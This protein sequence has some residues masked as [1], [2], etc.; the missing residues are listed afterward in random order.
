[1]VSVTVVVPTLNEAKSIPEVLRRVA[2]QKE[3]NEIIVVDGHSVDGTLEIARQTVPT[4]KI[5]IQ[6]GKGKGNALREGFE[7]ASGE[8][9]IAIDADGSMDPGQI[10]QFI[11]PLLDGYDFAKGSRFLPG[12]GTEDMTLLRKF[13]NKVFTLLVNILYRT[14]YS[15]CCYG[16][17]AFKKS[18][19]SA[20]GVKSDGFEIETEINV[21]AGKKRLRTMEV[22]SYERRRSFG[23]GN[24]HALKDGWRILKTIFL[25]MFRN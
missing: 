17:F 7:S 12:G 2:A 24:L 15:D 11:K 1:M 20:I 10:S 18:A 16:Y 14:R 23:E 13:G 3:I 25:E 5:V 22:P 8:I 6:T 9:V 21:R 4:I 19:F